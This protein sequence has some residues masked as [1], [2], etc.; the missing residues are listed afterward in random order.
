MKYHSICCDFMWLYMKDD[1]ITTDTDGKYI[2]INYKGDV[3]T[4]YLCPFCGKKL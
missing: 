4:L 2:I 3:I 1:K